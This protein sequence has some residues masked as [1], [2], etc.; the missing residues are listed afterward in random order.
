MFDLWGFFGRMTA[1]YKK[2]AKL[3]P[4]MLRNKVRKILERTR[5]IR[6]GVGMQIAALSVLSFSIVPTHAFDYSK[7][8]AEYLDGNKTQVITTASTYIYPVVEPTGVSQNYHG[9]HRGIDIR[10]P[11]GTP[12]VAIDNGTVIEV[13]EQSFGYGKHVR[14]AHNGTLSS[15]YAHLSKIEVKVGQRVK[16]GEEIGKVGSTGWSTGSHLH[17]EVMNGLNTVN[18]SGLI[19]NK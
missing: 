12:V 4:T 1:S 8:Q 15:L 10:A 13:Q 6:N 7:S 5:V 3:T 17:I 19:A 11:Q 16:A 9:L 14:I 18:P 2:G